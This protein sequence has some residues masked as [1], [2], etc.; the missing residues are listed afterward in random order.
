V[1][2]CPWEVDGDR[3]SKRNHVECWKRI[4][5]MDILSVLSAMLITKKK[6]SHV[7]DEEGAG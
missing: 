1:D 6:K 3:F 2:V 7:D 4:W 5:D